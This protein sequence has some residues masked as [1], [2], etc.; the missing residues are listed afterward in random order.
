ML[1]VDPA[2]RGAGIG[3]ELVG[4]A[5]RWAHDQGLER[6][7]LELLVPRTWAH[8]F[9]ELLRV[10]YTRIGYREVRIGQIEETY[11]ALGPLLATAC[12]FVV[13]RRHL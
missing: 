12:D 2:R 4:F 6:M 8:P 7:Q 3:R 5:E 10:W 9:K 13:Y 11:P 1:A